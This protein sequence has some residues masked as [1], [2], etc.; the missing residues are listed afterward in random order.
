MKRTIQSLFSLLFVFGS[1]SYGVSQGITMNMDEIN[2]EI[3]NSFGYDELLFT[4]ESEEAL[5]LAVSWEVLCLQESDPTKV[6]ICFGDLCFNYVKEDAV[7]GDTG[8][9]ALLILEP[10]ETSGKFK[11]TPSGNTSDGSKYRLNIFDR[12]NP[13]TVA[14]AIINYGPTC[15][16]SSVNDFLLNHADFNVYPNPVSGVLNV[17]TPHSDGAFYLKVYNII[18]RQVMNAKLENTSVNISNLTSGIYTYQIVQEGKATKARKLMV[19]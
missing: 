17:D 1:L 11:F 6:Q 18:G 9:S 15:S 10:G 14:S 19:R 8:P 12:N 4:N 5:E 16:S 7:W 3:G 13:E 2:I